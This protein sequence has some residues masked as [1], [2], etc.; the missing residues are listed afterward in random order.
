MRQELTKY[1][2]LSQGSDYAV[3]YTSLTGYLNRQLNVA[4]CTIFVCET[5]CAELLVN[6]KPYEI[7]SGQFLVLFF[8]TVLIPLKSSVDLSLFYF[9]LSQERVDEPLYAKPVDI[10]NFFFHHPL[11][12]PTAVQHSILKGWIEQLLWICTTLCKD[13]NDTS[14]QL[15]DRSASC[16]DVSL[17]KLVVN[18][19]ESFFLALEIIVRGSGLV[20]ERI[21]KASRTSVLLN[22]FMNLLVEHGI[23]NR[24]VAFYATQL[25]ITPDYLYKITMKEWQITPKK[26]IKN[27]LIAEIKILLTTSDITIKEISERLVFEDA[28]Y[29][30][31][32]F[33]KQV[34][35]TLTEYREK[36]WQ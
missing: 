27:Y 25:H 35:F 32:F 31:R 7:K 20:T 12:T 21:E 14:R 5:G 15:A 30:N 1:S 23:Q 22:Q 29:L 11:F 4:G 33:K 17:H 34:G 28:S 8:D 18:A 3:G 6:F 19:F 26:V 10:F 9:S 24:N 13:D 2:F 16:R 36:N